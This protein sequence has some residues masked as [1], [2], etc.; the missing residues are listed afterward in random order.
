MS[1]PNHLLSMADEPAEPLPPPPK[2]ES[3]PAPPPWWRSRLPRDSG[4]TVA[5]FAIAAVLL[6]LAG[7]ALSGTSGGGG[8][9]GGTVKAVPF[10]SAGATA[11]QA[12][13]AH[14]TWDLESAIGLALANSTSL[15]LNSSAF[16]NCTVTT[17]SG[18]LPGSLTIPSFSGNLAS[19]AA[20][21]WLF[22]YQSPV[23]GAELAVAVTGG[24]ANF[25]VELSGPV[26]S[27]STSNVTAFSSNPV[28]SSTAAT[29]VANAGGAAFL[30]AHPEGVSL[31][32]ILLPFSVGGRAA[33]PLWDF[34]YITCSVPLT[35]PQGPSP[36]GATFSAEVNGTSGAVV[37][38]TARTGTCGGPPTIPI[39]S[40]LQLGY[41]TAVSGGGRGG[42]LASQGCVSGD[43][44]Y[45]LAVLVALHNITPGDFQMYVAHSDGTPFSAVGFAIVNV[46]GAVVVYAVGPLETHWSAGVGS[47]TTRLT[48]AMTVVVD[49]GAVNPAGAGYMVW[50]TGTGQFANSSAGWGLP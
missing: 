36:P 40:A 1:D 14:G 41:P 31:E 30:A 25:V 37:P 15:P 45:S 39:S 24:V 28:D 4:V 5:I 12:G 47:S 21:S 42:T 27:T 26:C 35:G 46:S 9:R 2:P 44:C 38:G 3:P 49:M 50:V 18:P 32:M 8:A 43:Y 19:G 13:S 34:L 22:S 20:T 29:A 48:T 16:R 11:T 10:S 6:L 17:F 33:T 7:I 23:T